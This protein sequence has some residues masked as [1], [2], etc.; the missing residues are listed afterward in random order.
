[1]RKIKVVSDELTRDQLAN[2]F[3]K[4]SIKDRLVKRKS[5]NKINNFTSVDY[6]DLYG[7]A[8]FINKNKTF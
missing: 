5:V 1:L 2:P 3:P 4:G 7:K 8:V 6:G